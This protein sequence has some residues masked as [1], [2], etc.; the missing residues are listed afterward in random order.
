[1]INP[2][3]QSFSSMAVGSNGWFVSLVAFFEAYKIG[4]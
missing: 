2:S 4:A 3:Y 1:M